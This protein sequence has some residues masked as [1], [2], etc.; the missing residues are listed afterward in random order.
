MDLGNTNCK[1]NSAVLYMDG[2]VEGVERLSGK[3]K[4]WELL[5]SMPE[6]TPLAHRA[7]GALANTSDL[8]EHYDPN[9]AVEL[10]EKSLAAGCI[11]AGYDLLDIYRRGPDDLVDVSA[12]L[13]V[14]GKLQEYEEGEA[15]TLEGLFWIENAKR[16][17]EA[18][19]DGQQFESQQG[20]QLEGS[21]LIKG[22]KR[23]AYDAFKKA[24]ELT[25]ESIDATLG[26]I[27][28]CFKNFNFLGLP[29][30]AEE[31]IE[32][33]E[34]A[35]KLGEVRHMREVARLYELGCRKGKIK[36]NPEKA[37]YGNEQADA[38]EAEK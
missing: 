29:C 8:H 19:A 17:E 18:M 38:K 23:K 26:L 20:Q 37:K 21:E 3:R 13:R 24:T 31:I 16:V 14:L 25:P 1:Y 22:S 28:I 27:G 5:Q 30:S 9:A 33:L 12:Y 36:P 2:R 34:L 7:L 15:A 4:A 10:F 32:N 6:K 35:G 11:E